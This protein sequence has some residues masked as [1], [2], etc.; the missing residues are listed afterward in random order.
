M[1]VRWL[2]AGSLLFAAMPA[3]AQDASGSAD[4]VLTKSLVEAEGIVAAP[5]PEGA[6]PSDLERFL[7]LLEA[8]ERAAVGRETV[9]LGG[10]DEEA[11]CFN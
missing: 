9:G 10:G 1:C 11:N 3:F 8:G 2:I 7:R 4:A 5:V 6:L